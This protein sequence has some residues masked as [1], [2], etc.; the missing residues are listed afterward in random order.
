MCQVCL[1]SLA[2]ICDLSRCRFVQFDRSAHLLQSRSKS[3]DL[4]LLRCDG[5]LEFGDCARCVGI[6]QIDGARSNFYRA[7]RVSG[8]PRQKSMDTCVVFAP[9]ADSRSEINHTE[10]ALCFATAPISLSHSSRL[11]RKPSSRAVF[12]RNYWTTTVSAVGGS[13]SAA[14]I[15]RPVRP[16]FLCTRER[17]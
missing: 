7:V 6:R 15:D 1:L 11:P 14:S 2:G 17:T 3:F 16:L 12:Y 8:I 4:L 13:T 5:R 9:R 10:G